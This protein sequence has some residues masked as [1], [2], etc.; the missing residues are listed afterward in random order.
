[1]SGNDVYEGNWHSQCPWR[2]PVSLPQFVMTTKELSPN[3]TWVRPNSGA[4]FGGRTVVVVLAGVVVDGCVV[5]GAAVGAGAAARVVST[6]AGVA[7]GTVSLSPPHAAKM[8]MAIRAARRMAAEY[9]APSLLRGVWET[10]ENAS[11]S[12]GGQARD[13]ARSN[14]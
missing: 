7:V 10:S 9:T 11:S 6:G 1:M 14:G 3:T 4:A 12:R 13:S 2:F 5:A 8:R